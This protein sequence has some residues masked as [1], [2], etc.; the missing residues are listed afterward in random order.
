LQTK[1]EWEAPECDMVL[2][3]AQIV[4]FGGPLSSSLSATFDVTAFVVSGELKEE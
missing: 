3:E 1:V 2:T 4:A